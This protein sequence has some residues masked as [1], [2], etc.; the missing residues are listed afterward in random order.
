MN[1]NILTVNIINGSIG[2]RSQCEENV[3]M[4]S[5]NFDQ[6]LKDL[7]NYLINLYKKG[8]IWVRDDD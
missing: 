6:F 4:A 1:K 3:A 7:N 2:Y 8:E 5:T